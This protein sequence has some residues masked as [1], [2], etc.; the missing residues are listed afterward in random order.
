MSSSRGLPHVPVSHGVGGFRER[1]AERAAALRDFGYSAYDAEFLT[2]AA[3][4]GG[5]FLRRQYRAWGGR[6]PG[7]PERCMLAR[8]VE[9]GHVRPL[10]GKALYW[11]RGRSLYRAISGDG[12]AKGAPLA[13]RRIKAK[14]LAMDY[15]VTHG[16]GG[17]LL[18]AREKADRFRALGVPEESLPTARTAR[19]GSVRLFPG[20]FPIRDAAD[21]EST[22]EIVYAHAAATA[23]GMRAHL[24]M[25]APL[26]AALR[27]C[28][29]ACAWTVLADGAAQFPRLRHCWRGWRNERLRDVAESEYFALRRT[30]EKRQWERLS[31]EAVNRFADLQGELSGAGAERR[32]RRWLEDGARPLPAGADF[33]A[34]SLYREVLLDFD[35]AAADRVEA[36]SSGRE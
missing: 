1:I 11:I 15:V 19:S 18:D 20:G 13:R 31:G 8:A 17:W 9:H 30:V 25:H 29:V 22:V 24:R 2:A 10:A 35:Y 33:A 16:G 27:S 3:L 28:G 21:A 14:L 23:A 6:K 34:V 26:A 5:Y 12:P 4:L 36:R 7:S 32:Y